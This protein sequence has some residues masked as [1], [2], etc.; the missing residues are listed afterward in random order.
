MDIDYIVKNYLQNYNLLVEQLAYLFTDDDYKNYL[1]EL[2]NEPKDKKWNRGSNFNSLLT[3]DMFE[4]FIESK[5]KM[6]S[7][8]DDDSK[9]L[10]ESLFGEKLS[11]KKIFNNRDDSIK[12]MLWSYLHVLVLMTEMSQKKKNKDRIK[13]LTKLIESN[14]PE[15]E[16]SKEKAEKLNKSGMSDPKNMIKTMLGVDVNN[17]TNEMIEDIVKSFETSLNG[18]TANPFAGI[19]EI[20]KKISTKYSD[21][22]NK[23]D[24][25]L[26]KL[27]QGIQKSVPGMDKIM[28]N[29]GGGLGNMEGLG[30]MMG[31]MFQKEDKKQTVVIDENFSTA[32]VTQ[33][34][35]KESKS[36]NVS[37]LLNVADS[38]GILP[39]GQST[40]EGSVGTGLPNIPG[41]PNMSGLPNM[42]PNMM[43]LFNMMNGMDKID[44]KEKADEIKN[45]LDNFLE[46]NLGLDVNK[47]NNDIE[48]MVNKKMNGEDKEQ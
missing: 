18:N 41:L 6:F 29:V 1:L 40:N 37:K 24:I 12:F 45:K 14:V 20:S 4:V 21:K 42:P 36:I 5:M 48:N 31:G 8:K 44:S 23:G 13:R 33:G 26:D 30:D 17:E 7:H 25:E 16:K 9:K 38:F 2:N 27:M 47:I 19:F 11:L 39:G 35:I 46:K 22:I 28:S 32:D 34:Q 10:S 15:L 43:E 3:D